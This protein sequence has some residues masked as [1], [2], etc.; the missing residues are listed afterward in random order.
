MTLASHLVDFLLSSPLMERSYERR[1]VER[2][3]EVSAGLFRTSS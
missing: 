2:P 1:L 3:D